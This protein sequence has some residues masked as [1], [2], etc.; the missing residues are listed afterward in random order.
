M[1]KS[2]IGYLRVSTV[3]Q[4]QDGLGVEAQ[5]EA[6]RRHIEMV[7]GMLVAEYVEVESG[8]KHNRPVLVQSI[9]RCRVAKA[10]LIVARLDRLGR[11]VSQ[12]SNLMDNKVDFVAA[13]QPQAS[14]LILHLLASFGEW[15]REQISERTR[16]ALA[17]A[18]ARG[19]VLG[20]NGQNLARRH[21]AEADQYAATMKMPITEAVSFGCVT[22]RQ[23]AFYLTSAGYLTREGRDWSAQTVHRIMLRLG[24]RTLAMT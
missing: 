21:I 5:R 14:R 16:L 23:I 9:A 2:F 19:V 24:L 13:D 8:S 7:D 10:T 20:R 15:E 12:I 4:G 6:I 22:L 18:K 3:R 17:A 1:Q 11:T